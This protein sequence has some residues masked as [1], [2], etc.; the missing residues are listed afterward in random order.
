M[1]YLKVLWVHQ[2]SKD[3]VILMSELDDARYE[4]RKIEIFRD[5]R[6]GFASESDAS[7]GT[8]LGEKP[9]PPASE[10]ATDAQFIVEP[11]S[12]PE[13]EQAWLTAKAGN[14]WKT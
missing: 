9:V 7:D 11:L 1:E 3:P 5:G 10:I 14:R 6:M 13:F 8:I 2:G 4:V 12:A